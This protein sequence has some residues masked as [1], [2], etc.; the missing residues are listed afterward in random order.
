MRFVLIAASLAASLLLAGCGITSSSSAPL[1]PAPTPGPSETPVSVVQVGANVGGAPLALRVFD[2]SFALTNARSATAAELADVE[3]LDGN[4][5]GVY[6]AIGRE[7]LVTWR[8]N[9]CPGTG[10]LFIGPGV[11]E[12]V[13]APAVG[14]ECSNGSN[15][16]G[17]ALEFKLAV[18]LEAIHFDL[19]PRA[20][21]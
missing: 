10:D 15:V 19:R 7:I 4:A 14:A 20:N 1:Q 2:R 9:Q 11:D 6:H 21:A 3:Q 16:R 18:D 17:V 12:I 8:G 13:I 5:I